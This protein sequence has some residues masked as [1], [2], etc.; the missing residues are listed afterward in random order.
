MTLEEFNEARKLVDNIQKTKIRLENM[1]YV[2]TRDESLPETIHFCEV[3]Y[4]L[5]LYDLDA[6][7]RAGIKAKVLQAFEEQ[8]ERYSKK[9][10]KL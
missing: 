2:K 5:N 1:Q 10:E 8:L 9:L 7:L 4:S 6:D 3:D